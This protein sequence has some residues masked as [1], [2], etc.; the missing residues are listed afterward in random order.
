MQYSNAI[1]FQRAQWSFRQARGPLGGVVSG[2]SWID[3][4]TL[5]P[6][7]PPK[8]R[9]TTSETL[10]GIGISKDQLFT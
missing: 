8:S 1:L 10:N 4:Q 5:F 9:D 6:S 7:S 2:G 3:V